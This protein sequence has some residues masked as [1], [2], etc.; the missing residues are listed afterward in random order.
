MLAGLRGKI[1][2]LGTVVATA[3]SSPS[4]HRRLRRRR[5]KARALLRSAPSFETLR[6]K[7]ALELV[8][9]HHGSA[10]PLRAWQALRT[11]HAMAWFCRYRGA[12][13]W[14]KRATCHRCHFNDGEALAA[15]MRPPVATAA[16]A[17]FTRDAPGGGAA[18]SEAAQQERGRP[19]CPGAAGPWQVAW[20]SILACHCPP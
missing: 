6:A 9:A 15:V 7:S 4:W 3:P 13:E 17:P 12:N 10:V 19:L 20:L 14:E 1:L 11:T 8:L 16:S 5:A 2:L 18:L